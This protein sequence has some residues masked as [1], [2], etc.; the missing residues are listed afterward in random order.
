VPPSCVK[1]SPFAPTQIFPYPNPDM[2]WGMSGQNVLTLIIFLCGWPIYFTCERV[3][4]L[5]LFAAL[6][7]S[8]Q[9]FAALCSAQQA[10][11]TRVQIACS[12]H[13]F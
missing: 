11:L 2:K 6:C 3:P 10:V 8:L 12:L 4:A 5:Q 1:A 9:L 7:S 13:D